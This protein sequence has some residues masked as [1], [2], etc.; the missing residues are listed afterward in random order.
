MIRP[1]ISIYAVSG[2]AIFMDGARTQGVVFSTGVHGSEQLQAVMPMKSDEALRMLDRLGTP[3]IWV[4]AYGAIIWRGRLEDAQIVDNGLSITAYGYWRSL[5]DVPYTAL[6]STSGVAGWRLATSA[7]ISFRTPEKY[8]TDNNNRLSIA[9]TKDAVYSSGSDVCAWLYEFPHNGSRFASTINVTVSYDLPTNWVLR[10]TSRDAG[11]TETVNNITTTGGTA[12]GSSVSWTTSDTDAN[13]FVIE[14]FNNSGSSYTMTGETGTKYVTATAIRVRST[15]AS[16]TPTAIASDLIASA[17]Q[18]STSTALIAT[19]SID[20][21]NEIY[22]DE[23]PADI[24]TRLAGLGDASGNR[25]EA[26]VD[27]LKRLYYRQVGTGAREWFLNA[28]S[29]QLQRSLGDLYNSVYPVY[30]EEGGRL[31]R[32]ATSTDATSTGRYGITRR[33]AL[34]VDTTSSTQADYHRDVYLA[35]NKSLTPRAAFRVR[36]IYGIGTAPMPPFLVKAGDYVT[37]NNLPPSPDNTLNKARRFR[38][39][40]TEYDCETGDLTIEPEMPLPSLDFIVAREAAGVARRAMGRIR[41]G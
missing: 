17:A 15:S 2:G 9:L 6:W 41:R 27:N 10:V 12:S 19:N 38:I 25:W 40:R 35:D 11:G 33:A 24:L 34:D 3:D 5:S 36:S 29:I 30:K 13:K 31:L 28:E 21:Q 20:L 7:D 14:A 22:E 32:G 4:F 16:A 26:G 1:S 8:T 37:V 23:Y 18:L 39:T